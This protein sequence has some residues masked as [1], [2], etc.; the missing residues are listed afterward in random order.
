MTADVW[1]KYTIPSQIL[2]G[3]GSVHFSQQGRFY[4]KLE[5]DVMSLLLRLMKIWH[6]Y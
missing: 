1:G 4:F 2:V 3:F 6:R 5:Y